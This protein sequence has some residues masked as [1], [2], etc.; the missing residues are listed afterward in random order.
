MEQ[1]VQKSGGGGRWHLEGS[2]EAA[3]VFED[4]AVDEICLADGGGGA[5]RRSVCSASFS[6]SI[7]HKGAPVNPKWKL[8]VVFR[9]LL[10][11]DNHAKPHLSRTQDPIGLARPPEPDA[12][13]EPIEIKHA[14][15]TE[16]PPVQARAL[17]GEALATEAALHVSRGYERRL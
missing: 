5:G 6:G 15:R 8:A 12:S 2:G 9:R 17:W 10:V 7:A 14:E 4:R 1:R 11:G 16:C 3:V 13:A